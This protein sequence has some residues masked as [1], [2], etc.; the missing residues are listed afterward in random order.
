[1]AEKKKQGEGKTSHEDGTS[2]PDAPKDEEKQKDVSHKR[3]EEPIDR[4]KPD[5]TP[6]G[7]SI[8]MPTMLKEEDETM[9]PE[10]KLSRNHARPRKKPTSS[11]WHQPILN[12]CFL[13]LVIF[14][15]GIP[16]VEGKEVSHQHARRGLSLS[17]TPVQLQTGKHCRND[18]P[19][20]I[21]SEGGG[22]T[23]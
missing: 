6:T 12:V 17:P 5:S 8:S 14:F 7:K 2:R 16:T 20:Y 22:F 3:S 19:A 10:N 9:D 23:Q 1:M 18:D 4:G 11:R 15:V 21:A 13:L